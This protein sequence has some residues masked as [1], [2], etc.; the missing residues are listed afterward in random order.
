MVKICKPILRNKL[1]FIQTFS[2]YLND[3]REIYLLVD[4]A[5]NTT[6]YFFIIILLTSS[7]FFLPLKFLYILNNLIE[8]FAIILD[9]LRYCKFY[10]LY[11]PFI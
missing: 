11:I 8:I 7:S 2:K 1:N 5:I 6:E 3:S 10:W 4:I 9:V